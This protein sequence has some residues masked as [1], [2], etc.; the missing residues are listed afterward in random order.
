VQRSAKRKSDIF[1][2]IESKMSRQ[3]I[4]R[5]DAKARKILLALRLADFRRAMK[6]DQSAVRG[7]SQPDISKIEGRADIKLSTL[8]EYCH[9]LGAEIEIAAKPAK[10]K[11]KRFVL[12]SA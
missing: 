5:S 8:V 2:L 6:V 1:E 11:G 3:S 10:K 9:G 4:K 7:F 12:L